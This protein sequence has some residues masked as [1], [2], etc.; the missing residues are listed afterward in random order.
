MART[1]AGTPR[2]RRN[3]AASGRSRRP[4][5]TL[6]IIGARSQGMSASVA[7][8]GQGC[9]VDQVQREQGH[10]AS[11]EPARPVEQLRQRE[12]QQGDRREREPL[13]RPVR[14]H[15][16]VSGQVEHRQRGEAPDPAVD[17]GRPA[18]AVGSPAT[19]NRPG[20]RRRRE[21]DRPEPRVEHADHDVDERPRIPARDIEQA[22]R[23]RP[24]PEPAASQ[25]RPSA[26]TWSG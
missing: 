17:G 24:R 8:N 11:A 22:V 26:S 4:G 19:P 21:P 25:T 5:T 2:P 23:H 7:A 9:G 18:L 12:R 6:G 16:P 3:S 10:G 13:L 1:G 14:D 20:A 15:H